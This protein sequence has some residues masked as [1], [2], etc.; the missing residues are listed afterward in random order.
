MHQVKRVI[1][2]ALQ[3]EEMRGRIDVLVN[4][5]GIQ[6][7]NPSTQF[8]EEDWDEVSPFIL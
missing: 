8:T 5:G 6:R 3:L 1:D 7:R 2:E 4:C